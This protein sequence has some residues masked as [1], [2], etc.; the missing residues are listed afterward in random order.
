MIT[1]MNIFQLMSSLA[2]TMILV[3]IIISTL[4]ATWCGMLSKDTLAIIV[5]AIAFTCYAIT[6][7][8]FYQLWFQLDAL[9]VIILTIIECGFIGFFM[10]VKLFWALREGWHKLKKGQFK[11]ETY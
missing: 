4:I 3:F 2:P 7:N 6:F 11:V 5:V 1:M 8:V 10:I 9:L